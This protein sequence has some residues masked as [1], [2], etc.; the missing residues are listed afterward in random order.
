M[1]TMPLASLLFF[2]AY[3][4]G[5]ASSAIIV[6]RALGLPDPRTE[7]SKNPGATNVLRIAGKK[8]AAVVLFCDILKGFIPVYVSHLVA[9]PVVATAVIGLSAVMGHMFPIYYRFHGGKGVATAMGVFFGL[10]FMLGVVACAVWLLVLRLFSYSS[11]ASMVTVIVAPFASLNLLNTIEAFIPLSMVMIFII[12]K[13]HANIGR[14]IE[15]EE[16]KTFFSG[17]KGTLFDESDENKTPSEK[18][19]SGKKQTTGSK[20][21]TA[22][23]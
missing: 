16:P 2:C 21:S 10:N 13:H 12:I 7:G 8:E 18:A 9:L 6:C 20:K 17:F 3:F 1:E 15:G 23:K 11:L 22:S 14:L 4:L 5:S 19:A